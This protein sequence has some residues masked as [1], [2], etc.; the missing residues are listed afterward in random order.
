MKDEKWMKH[1]ICHVNQFKKYG[2]LNF[3]IKYLIESMRRG[4]HNNKYE[5]EASNAEEKDFS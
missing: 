3:I 2:V 1:E 5:I 4:Y